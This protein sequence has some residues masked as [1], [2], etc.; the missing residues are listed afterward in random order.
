MNPRGS[1]GARRGDNRGTHH[2]PFG[3]IKGVRP[4]G[5]GRQ[6]TPVPGLGR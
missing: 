3:I 1:N 5:P 4:G 2:G 6:V